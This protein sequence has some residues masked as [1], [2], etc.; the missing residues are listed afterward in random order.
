M[1]ARIRLR[2]NSHNMDKDTVANALW[3]TLQSENEED[4]NGE[5]ANV[6][7]ALKSIARGLGAVAEAIDRFG[8]AST[9]DK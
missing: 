6:V 9:Q 8:R 2:D 1:T 3:G 5:P 7:D 4:R